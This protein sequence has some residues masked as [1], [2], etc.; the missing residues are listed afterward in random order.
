METIRRFLFADCR[1]GRSTSWWRAIWDVVG[2]KVV[3]G[4]WLGM[5]GRERGYAKTCFSAGIHGIRYKFII[6][7]TFVRGCYS[8][9]VSELLRRP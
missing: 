2:D 7:R 4:D 9:I 5:R 8:L 1:T 6:L 3:V